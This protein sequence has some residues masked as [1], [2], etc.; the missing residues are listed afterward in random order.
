MRAGL[1]DLEDRL[2][3]LHEVARSQALV[4][5]KFF[6]LKTP[7]K[8]TTRRTPTIFHTKGREQVALANFVFQGGGVLGIAHLGFLHAMEAI[9][10]RAVG[11]AGTSA[12]AIVA[13]LIVAARGR[14]PWYPVADRLLPFLSAMPASSFI[15]G[16]YTARRLIKF[17]LKHKN[18][19][20]LEM[21]VPLVSSARRLLRAFG[22]NSGNTFQ[23]WLSGLLEKEFDVRTVDDLTRNVESVA[24][25]LKLRNVDSHLLLQIIA[26]ALPQAGATSIPLGTKFVFPRDYVVL[27][28]IYGYQ[29][30]ALMARA[31]MSVPLFFEPLVLNLDRTGWE[32][33]IE[34]TFGALSKDTRHELA[35][36]PSVAFVDGGLLSNFPIDAFA[37]VSKNK[38]GHRDSFHEIPTL[39]VALSSS[40]RFER[41]TAKKGVP[42]FLHHL[43]AVI[44]GMRHAR[45]RDAAST[46]N[47]S[48]SQHVRIALIDVGQHGWL[49]FQLE[50]HDIRDLFL[51]G[52]DAATSFIEDLK[53]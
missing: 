22:L 26:T 47:K 13:I 16:P 45:D 42:A 11:V 28:P 19:A 21:T 31:S 40:G 6:K 33:M 17:F 12:G 29:S 35:T 4:L 44:D 38:T 36:A 24:A 52:V 39:G 25:E 48:G 30:P 8:E 46:A 3:S 51:R 50:E 5:E 1:G 53:I 41:S 15:D 23:D 18:I 43:S 10:V 14:N 9:G 20:N 2:A 32:E 27:S 34:R 7:R 49:N 37:R